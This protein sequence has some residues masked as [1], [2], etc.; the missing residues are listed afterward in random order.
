MTSFTRPSVTVAGMLI[1]ETDTQS[2]VMRNSA[3]TAWVVILTG[4]TLYNT[5]NTTVT[6]NSTSFGNGTG[7][8]TPGIGFVA[9]PSGE[10]LLHY[11]C[12]MTPGATTAQATQYF[13]PHV[14]TGASVDVGTDV[15]VA[16]D[17]DAFRFGM[18]GVVIKIRGGAHRVIPSLTP[19][20]TYN[21]KMKVKHAGT[22]GTVEE[23]KVIVQP[24]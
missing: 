3:N 7:G 19:G 24:M 1:Y 15:V 23:M 17:A 12:S 4:Q 8:T 16:A 22:A 9:P 2:L 10:V 13:A 20:Q 11:S 5:S 14:K 6:T 18:G 21:V